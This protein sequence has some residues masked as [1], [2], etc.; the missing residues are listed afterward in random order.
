M[1]GKQFSCPIC[2]NGPANIYI[3][4]QKNKVN[5]YRCLNCNLVFIPQTDNPATIE[6]QYLNDKTSP[7]AYYIATKNTDTIYFSRNLAVAEKYQKPG[8]IL[9]VGCNIGTFM[10]T[11]RARNWE[12]I[13]IEPNPKACNYAKNAGLKV[14]NC[15]FTKEAM[16][17]LQI[18]GELPLLDAVHLGDVIEHVLDPLTMLKLASS[19]LKPG[20]IIVIST[21]NIESYFCRKYQIKPREH[22]IYFSPASIKNALIRSGFRLEYC[23]RQTR[24]RDIATM[25][26][27]TVAKRIFENIIIK[28]AQNSILRKII[29]AAVNAVA[30]D[31]L[32][33]IGKKQ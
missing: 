29:N 9:D 14:F 17:G 22:F 31:E 10:K 13:G 25:G 23:R 30:N 6:T 11:A 8:L 3:Y 5:L 4:S 27:S 1:Q 7:I 18:A 28:L 21:P 19:L 16:S 2:K 15:F 26:K 20:G 33:V 24:L 12:P 32:L